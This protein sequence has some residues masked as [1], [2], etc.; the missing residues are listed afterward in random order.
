MNRKRVAPAEM[1]ILRYVMDHEPATAREVADAMSETKGFARSTTQT[2][3]ERLRGKEYLSR[4]TQNGVNVYRLSIPKSELMRELV[5]DFV[6]SSLG[7]SMSPFVAYLTDRG[8][9]TEEEAQKLAELL[10]RVEERS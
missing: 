7:G 10:R 8:S 1:E 6:E 3:M 4:E 5:S 2:L 9:L